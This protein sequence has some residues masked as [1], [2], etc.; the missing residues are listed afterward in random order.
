MNHRVFRFIAQR[1]VI[2][3]SLAEDTARQQVR[4][5]IVIKS[6]AV[7][8]AIG[9]AVHDAVS[10]PQSRTSAC[11]SRRPQIFFSDMKR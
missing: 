3:R 11:L 9:G 10:L 2:R 1:R 7:T 6:S 4:A 8:F 5:S